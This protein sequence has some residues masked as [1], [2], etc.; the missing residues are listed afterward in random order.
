MSLPGDLQ[1]TK[2]RIF[3]V[4]M[5]LNRLVSIL[6]FEANRSKLFL[7]V[8]PTQKTR[9]EK[10]LLKKSFSLRK[11]LGIRHRLIFLED[12]DISIARMLVEGAD[13]WLNTPRRPFEALWHIRN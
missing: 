7:Q 13:V 9:K 4:L 1:P 2:D 11:V 5:H 3:C 8:K 10:T 6:N 12:Y